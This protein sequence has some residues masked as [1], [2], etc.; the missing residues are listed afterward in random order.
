MPSE[1]D[2]VVSACGQYRYASTRQVGPGESS[3]DLRGRA[4]VKALGIT[5][6]VTPGPRAPD[7]A[8]GL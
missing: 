5:T 7:A 1:K 8:A 6:P 4:A 2:A 3:A